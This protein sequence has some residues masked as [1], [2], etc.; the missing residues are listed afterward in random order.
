M[1]RAFTL[2]E[3]LVVIA[4]IAILAAILFPVF[5]QAKLAAKKATIVSNV[6]QTSLGMF[7]YQSD[8]DDMF[9]RAQYCAQ[10][11]SL[12]PEMKA[13]VYN[14]STTTGC[15][16]NVNGKRNYN[17]VDERYW[18]KFLMPYVKSVE[19][20]MHPLRQKD[21]DGWSTYGEIYNN[22]VIN[23]GLT[24]MIHTNPATGEP[25]AYNNIVSFTGGSQ[26]GIPDVASAAM[27]IDNVPLT[28]SGYAPTL[29]T[30]QSDK[31]AV[32]VGYPTA[33]REFWA[34]RLNKMTPAECITN[35]QP[36]TGVDTGK[37]PS[38]GLTVGRADGSAK[39]MSAALF[40]AKSPP[41][42]EVYG[43]PF[44]GTTCWVGTTAPIYAEST[45]PAGMNPKIDY[46][47]WGFSK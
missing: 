41:Q 11:S 36:N 34:Y 29:A 33:D 23:L 44:T 46:P 17:Y 18:Q 6:K 32:A 8:N 5:A 27:F 13:A 20:F 40:L 47:L 37:V 45:A 1:K 12:N 15:T 42:A 30:F 22:T 14:T 25:Y 31:T 39:F 21:A 26:S 10:G 19:L 38:G 7:L 3:L 16:T 24:G 43:G 28:L 2:I 35:P 4:I 9:F